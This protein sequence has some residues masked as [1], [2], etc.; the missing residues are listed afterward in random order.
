MKLDLVTIITNI[1]AEAGIIDIMEDNLCNHSTICLNMKEGIPTIYLKKDGDEVWVWAKLMEYN[2]SSLTYFSANLLP[3]ILE[4]NEAIFY[5][6]QPCLYPI[7]GNL[8]LRAQVKDAWLES[9]DDF[10]SMLDHYLT[11]LQNYRAV[12]A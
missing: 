12:L 5:A 11:I 1:L 3:L 10:L 6:G 8:E 9:P 4:H 7:E 2:I